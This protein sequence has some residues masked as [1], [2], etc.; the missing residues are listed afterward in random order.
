M[1]WDEIQTRVAQESSKR[2]DLMVYR[3]GLGHHS[4]GLRVQEK[5]LPGQFFF[6]TG[7]LRSR[8]DLLK[9]HLP[10]EVAA[11]IVEADSI[12]EHRFRLLGYEDIQYG[13]EIDWHLDAIHG[14][15][16]PLKPWY[17]IHFLDFEEVGDHKITWE[18]NRHQHFVTLAKAWRFTGK[19]TYINELLKQWYDW[20]T[21]NPYPMGIN[22]SSSLEA[23]FRSLSWIWVQQLL[24]DCE[25][26][27]TDFRL[28]LAQALALHARYIERYL[29]TYFSPNT[30]LLGEAVALFF[31]GT[32]CPQ[33]DSAE[34]C[35]KRGWQ[36]LI[37]EA[38]R[39]VRP[40]GVYFEQSLYYHVYALDLFLHARVL[41]AGNQIDVP[42]EFDVTI[43][44]M[45]EVVATVSQAGLI[46]FG[47]DDGG[48][49]FN[50]CRNR[51]EHLTDPIAIG[52]LLFERND[53]KNA[54]TLTE[55]AIWLF[56]ETAVTSLPQ[57]KGEREKIRSA[58]FE[59]GGIFLLASTSEKDGQMQMMIDAGPQGTANSGHGHADAL[60]IQ[61]SLH[62]RPLLVDS[63][64]FSYM[65]EERNLFRGTA[66]HNTMQ[67]DGFDQAVPEG[68]FAWSA[69]PE[70][71]A[72]KWIAGETF[73]LFVGSHNGYAR[74]SD[75]VIHRR[76]VF[77]L[78]GCFWLARDVA[79]GNAPHRLQTFWHFAPNVTLVEHKNGFVAFPSEIAPTPRPAQ[80]G[81]IPV[82]DPRWSS[83]IIS[84]DVSQVY[85]KKEPAAILE[86]SAKLKLP[87][88]HATLLRPT[89]GVPNEL[90]T[91]R[92]AGHTDT[93]VMAYRYEES[94]TTHVMIFAD[95]A[96]GVWHSCGI[97]S[98]A[99]LVYFQV[100]GGRL[101]HFI[102]CE[103][104][105]AQIDG[106]PILSHNKTIERFEWLVRR[107]IPAIF[108]SDETAANSWSG[109][110]P[111]SF[112]SLCLV[113]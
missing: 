66:A 61:V 6:S 51:P 65:S 27:P 7:E 72:E 42:G 112:H 95:S 108:S 85:G 97:S 99:R 39:Q 38:Q 82:E 11:L 88:E 93:G 110:A 16:A 96:H 74:L 46:A 28:K 37:E 57:A 75:P 80:L 5:S 59:S 63:G 20:Q 69:I 29:S 30:H 49:L 8:T 102:L 84:G 76:F 17:K 107:G 1:S 106:S 33:F 87:A 2:L 50:P 12:L 13:S 98:D 101:I 81:L 78:H 23:A 45:L 90:G 111:E 100:N 83:Q 54:A 10:S 55:E 77:H 18:L 64:T 109:N 31:I 71:R 43:N 21:A 92:S 91:L 19:Q 86:C 24:T 73:S 41:A 3:L 32:L 4:N 104:R 103:G 79:V 67:V 9:K 36:I 48:R 40:D 35:R 53:L 113:I 56:G 14:K 62:G 70:V 22:W 52:A 105:S 34:R 94:G 89:T 44:K 68:P 47:D 60:A 15:R 26:V 58:A 25:A